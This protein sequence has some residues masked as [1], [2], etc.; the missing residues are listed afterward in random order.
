MCRICEWKL[1]FRVVRAVGAG[2]LLG[3]DGP[4]DEV[5]L[6]PLATQT[7]EQARVFACLDASRGRGQSQSLAGIDGRFDDGAPMR[8][9]VGAI[10]EGAINPQL[11][12]RD[13]RER[14]CIDE[15]LMPSLAMD[16]PRRGSAS[17]MCRR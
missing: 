15:K 5:I 16:R 13:T 10:H 17:A 12:E 11:R 9:A 8:P 1:F 7:L 2:S 6:G 3:G 4:R 14:C